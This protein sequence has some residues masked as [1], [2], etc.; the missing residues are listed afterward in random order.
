MKIIVAC[1]GGM[2]TNILVSRM[3]K[4]AQSRNIDCEIEAI[5]RCKVEN[6]LAEGDADLLLL[7]PQLMS[8]YE[9]IKN[10]APKNIKVEI[11]DMVKFG[12]CDGHATLN[13]AIDLIENRL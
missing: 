13:F 1:T 7:T 2:S 3:K 9:Q 10:S 5:G 12:A 6:I 4:E 11:L 8:E